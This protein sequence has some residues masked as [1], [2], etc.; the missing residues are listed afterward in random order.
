MKIINTIEDMNNLA[1]SCCSS[2]ENIDFSD[3]CKK[4]VMCPYFLPKEGFNPQM[5]VSRFFP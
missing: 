1:K 5:G 4:D 3:K 2:C